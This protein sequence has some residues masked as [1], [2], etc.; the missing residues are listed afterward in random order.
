MILAAVLSSAI[1][2]SSGLYRDASGGAIYVGTEHELPY[3]AYSQYLDAGTGATGALSSA[4]HLRQ[5]C[6]LHEERRFVRRDGILGVSLFYAAAGSR[7]TIMLIHG[8][9][10]ETREMGWIV[11]YF[12]CNGVNVVSYDQRGTG[13]SSGDWRMNGPPERARDAAAIFDAFRGDARVDP[14]RIGVWG[15]SNG[16]WTAPIVAADRPLAFMI[17]QSAP[18]ESVELNTL[19]EAEQTMRS[20]GH[21][22]T[23]IDS[24]I[25]TWQAV[26]GALYGQTPIPTAKKL[27]AQ[28]RREAWF[29]DSLLP[30]FSVRTGFTEPLLSGWRRFVGYDPA[31]VLEKVRTPTLALYGGKDIKTDVK[32]DLPVLEEAFRKAGMRDLTVRWFADAGHTM[33]VS[34]DGYT[35]RYPEVMLDWLQKRNLIR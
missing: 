34:P 26:F 21:N 24:A 5:T 27:Y 8:S 16:G 29:A 1:L 23:E 15:F 18:A 12:A 4:R 28:A 31:P 33:K 25:A 13:M 7:A 30:F 11:T 22:Q 32:H 17:L 10:A 9:D 6:K 14:R 20:A 35:R 19:Y 3:A 2:I